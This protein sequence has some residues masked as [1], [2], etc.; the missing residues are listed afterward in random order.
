MHDKAQ[1]AK[2]MKPYSHTASRPSRCFNEVL[3]DLYLDED[4]IVV[5]EIYPRVAVI[6]YADL[7]HTLRQIL[8]GE[9]VVYLDIAAAVVVEGDGERLCR[10]NES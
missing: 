6:P 5:G 7:G 4:R 9:D 1:R 8:C 3:R 2:E 10:I